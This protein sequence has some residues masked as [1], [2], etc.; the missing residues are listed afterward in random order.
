MHDFD[1][2]TEE[3]L[4]QIKDYFYKFDWDMYAFRQQQIELLIK[5]LGKDVIV[6]LKGEK[7]LL[8]YY[9]GE[10]DEESLRVFISM[11]DEEKF[12]NFKSITPT[13]RRAIANFKIYFADNDNLTVIRT[14]PEPFAQST[15]LIKNDTTDWRI[16]GRSFTQAND[17]LIDENLF[18]IIKGISK[19]LFHANKNIKTID[20]V[21]HFTQIVATGK[22]IASNSPEGIHQ[23]GMDYIVS[24]LVVDRIN[25]KGGKSIIYCKDKTT[26]IFETVLMPGFGL[27]QPDAGTDL[28]H[29]VEPIAPKDISKPAFRSTIG[30]DFSY[31]C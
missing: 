14:T 21:L 12:K 27:M 25:V 31:R 11:L 20:L 18:N 5:N 28:W 26:P 4:R 10:L 8:N 6:E 16:I 22:G 19:R 7:F 15:A 13:R 23:D 2:D 1:V 30:F 24:A 9:E 17:S 29:T 3:Y